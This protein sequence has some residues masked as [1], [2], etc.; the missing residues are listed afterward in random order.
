MCVCVC[1]GV[2]VG[3]ACSQLSEW[4]QIPSQLSHAGVI[5]VACAVVCGLW[6][7]GGVVVRRWCVA[8]VSE[9]NFEYL[10][11]E[12]GVPVL[13]VLSGPHGK[14]LTIKALPWVCA[15][16]SMCLCLSM[17]VMALSGGVSTKAA[18]EI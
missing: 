6:C 17:D 3:A 16:V 11:H 4:N 2:L 5:V 8:L 15:C 10:I 7:R 12:H 9:S 18:P 1:G 13:H 14:C